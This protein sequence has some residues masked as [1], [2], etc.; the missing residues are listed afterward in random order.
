MEGITKKSARSKGA[1]VKGGGTRMDYI[2]LSGPGAEQG[3]AR[4]MLNEATPTGHFYKIGFGWAK[5]NLTVH[6][7]FRSMAHDSVSAVPFSGFIP[8][9]PSHSTYQLVVSNP[10]VWTFLGLAGSSTPGCGQIM[11]WN[12]DQSS[13]S[14]QWRCVA[15]N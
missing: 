3:E 7:R 14:N 13:I 15:S 1:K 11:A 12:H 4:D 2:A 10:T 6:V 5:P 9:L 8:H